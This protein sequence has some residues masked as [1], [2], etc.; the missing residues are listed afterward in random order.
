MSKSFQII[1]LYVLLLVLVQSLRPIENE[2][3]LFTKDQIQFKSNEFKEYSETN[4]I[5]VKSN[6]N[7]NILKEDSIT[8]LHI[9]YDD[10]IRVKYIGYQG[11]LNFVLD[12]ND[13]ETNI[14]CLMHLI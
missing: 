13:N 1:A 6:E 5:S 9:E 10:N 14:M 2:K 12:H 4:D 3:Y 8:E 11:I 7:Q